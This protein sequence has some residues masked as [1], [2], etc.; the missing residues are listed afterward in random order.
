MAAVLKEGETVSPH[1]LN[2]TTPYLFIAPAALVILALVVYPILNGIYISFFNTNL[3][4]KWEFVGLKYYLK[5]LTDTDFRESVLRTFKFTFW[6]VLG[7]FVIGFIIASLVNRP[8][9]GRSVFRGIL[10]LPWIFPDVVV[11]LLWKWIFNTQNGI[12]NAFLQHLGLVNAPV[13]WLSSASTAMLCVIFVSIWKGFPLVMVQ[14]LAGLQTIPE[15]LYEAAK[16]DG[17]N[18]F[19]RFRYVTIPSLKPIISTVLILDTVWVFK[20][21]TLVYIQTSGG[22]GSATMV[23]AIEIYKRAFSYFEFGYASAESVFI[24]V[25]CY[26]I[27]KIFRRLMDSE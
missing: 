25:I 1:K 26:A 5:A 16:I 8:L 23:S 12:L 22:P 7:H 2:K 10:I 6:V 14:L 21:F 9:K 13:T 3:V 19:Q 4:N 20:Q 18:A 24:L 17:A 11:A 15:D 27:G